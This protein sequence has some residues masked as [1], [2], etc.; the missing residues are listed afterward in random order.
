MTPGPLY[1]GVGLIF[2]IQANS[3]ACKTAH[4]VFINDN[5]RFYSVHIFIGGQKKLKIMDRRPLQRL[6]H[7]LP[8]IWWYVH[9]CHDH[10]SKAATRGCPR[11]LRGTGKSL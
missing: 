1:E 10:F 6:D 11:T 3:V 7:R 9:I 2:G 8:E 4:V 5:G